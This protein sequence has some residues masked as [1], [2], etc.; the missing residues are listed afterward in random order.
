VPL[1]HNGLVTTA[2]AVHTLANHFTVAVAVAMAGTYCHANA[3]R[4][5]TDTELFR[6]RRLNDGNSSQR[7][8]RYYKMPDHRMF[9]SMKLSQE[10]FVEM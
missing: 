7:D 4:T 9:L 2:I 5:N 1:D 3:R 6:T 8:G 10:Q